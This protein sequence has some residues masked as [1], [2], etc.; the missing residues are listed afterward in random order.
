MKIKTFLIYT[1]SLLFLSCQSQ[2]PTTDNKE[3][4]T[5]VEEKIEETIE[6]P[7][8]EPEEVVLSKE[9]TYTEHSLEDTYEYKDQ[10]R[11]FQWNK[12]RE[13]LQLI[14]VLRLER[15]SMWGTLKNKSNTNGQAPIAKENKRDIYNSITDKYDIQRYQAIPLYMESDLET[16][17]RYAYDGSLIRIIDSIDNFIIAKVITIDST[18]YIPEKYVYIFDKAPS[19]NKVIVVDRNFQ[20]I[21]T[22][23]KEDKLWKVRSMNPCTTGAKKPPHQ[24]ATPLGLFV[25]QNHLEKMFYY[26]DGTTI[27][28]GFAPWATRFTMGGYIHGVPVN[29]INGDIIEYSSTLGT[30]PRSHMCVRNASSHAKFIYDNFDAN[31][32]LVFVIE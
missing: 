28:A 1:I 29:N 25:V 7:K 16:P 11:S 10:I 12:I 23:E 13:K 5:F 22:Y 8:P 26:E 4:D 27:I 19:F 30:I 15:D 14:E 20:N 3:N 24:K 9:L 6:I 2:L 18:Y 21:S 31:E 32:A 17:E